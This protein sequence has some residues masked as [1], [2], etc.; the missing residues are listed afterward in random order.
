MRLV[1]GM[2]LS[3]CRVKEA[4]RQPPATSPAGALRTQLVIHVAIHRIARYGFTVHGFTVNLG[5]S[6]AP[7][8]SRVNASGSGRTRGSGW[9]RG[10][11]ARHGHGRGGGRGR[12]WGE[13]L[14][15]RKW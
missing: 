13:K 9:G 1:L 5:E 7:R 6:R 10:G 2:L 3:W 8:R 11:R 4:E 14:R 12:V 15:G